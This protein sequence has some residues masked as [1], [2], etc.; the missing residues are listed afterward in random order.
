MLFV[1]GSE[2]VQRNSTKSEISLP[3]TQTTQLQRTTP[4]LPRRAQSTGAQEATSQSGTTKQTSNIGIDHYGQSFA[5]ACAGITFYIDQIIF[6][7]FIS[8]Y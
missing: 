8:I 2:T 4:T 5:Y 6:F 3:T 1:F 7:I